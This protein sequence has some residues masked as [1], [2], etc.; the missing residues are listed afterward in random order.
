MVGRDSAVSGRL[1][2]R[3]NAARSAVVAVSQVTT[4]SEAKAPTWSP[5]LPTRWA[6]DAMSGRSGARNTL[7][8]AAAPNSAAAHT[9]TAAAVRA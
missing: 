9:A 5:W 2:N 7:Q 4:K 3:C 8:P 6:M 1:M